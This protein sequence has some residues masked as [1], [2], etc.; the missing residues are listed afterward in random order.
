ML[1]LFFDTET[2]GKALNFKAPVTN[3]DNWPRLVQLGFILCQDSYDNKVCE[4]DIIIR[5]DGF[6]IPK[7]ATDIHGISH[8]K[9]L[10][11]GVEISGVLYQFSDLIEK[12]D[13][14]VGHNLGFDK[15]VIGAEMIRYGFNE[16]LIMRKPSLDTMLMS[17][18]FCQIPGPY[19]YKWPKLSELHTKLFN[20]EFD[21]AHNA[22]ADIE[23]TAKCFFELV[24]I[25]VIKL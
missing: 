8:E 20:K 9:A 6:L 18:N 23:A 5:P 4:G 10:N 21:N 3:I 7:A 24:K 16:S 14:L 25:G 13:Y 19:G 15:P 17:T 22:F 1:F 2:T 11:E 12:A